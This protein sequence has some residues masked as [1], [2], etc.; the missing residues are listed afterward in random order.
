[1]CTQRI[2]KAFVK[3]SADQDTIDMVE[4]QYFWINDLMASVPPYALF[5][6]STDFRREFVKTLRRKGRIHTVTVASVTQSAAV[7]R[8]SQPS[9]NVDIFRL[10]YK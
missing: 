3:S 1:M 8:N 6:F 7:N 10:P 2:V 9:P 4:M 5:F